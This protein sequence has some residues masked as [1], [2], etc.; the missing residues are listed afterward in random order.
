[1]SVGSRHS[2]KRDQLLRTPP[3]SSHRGG[4]KNDPLG[5]SQQSQLSSSVAAS[6]TPGYSP[7]VD[8]ESPFNNQKIGLADRLADPI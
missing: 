1:M 6:H 2:N 7:T 3:P 4:Y 5:T 8:Q